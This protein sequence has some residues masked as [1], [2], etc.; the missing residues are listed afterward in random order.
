M[1]E[2]KSRDY[3]KRDFI[4]KR[5]DDVERVRVRVCFGGS[6]IELVGWLPG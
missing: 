1:N 4:S 3:F 2:L 5:V 6:M